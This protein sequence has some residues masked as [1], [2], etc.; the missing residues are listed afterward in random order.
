MIL[1]GGNRTGQQSSRLALAGPIFVLS[2]QKAGTTSINHFLESLGLATVHNWMAVRTVLGFDDEC[3]EQDSEANLRDGPQ[4]PSYTPNYH[5]WLSS[6]GAANMS[7]VLRRMPV[8]AWLDT[9]FYAMP[10]EF[11]DQTLP[12]ARFV[13]WARNSTSWADSMLNYFS[14][15]RDEPMRSRQFRHSYGHCTVSAENMTDF[16][17]AYEAHIAHVRNYFNAT[18]GRHARL[19]DFD[20]E[21]PTAGKQLCEFVAANP[22]ECASR[23]DGDSIPDE[24]PEDETPEEE[25]PPEDTDAMKKALREALLADADAE[26]E[27]K[28]DEN[29]ENNPVND[30]FDATTSTPKA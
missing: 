2:M 4:P 12:R 8:D 23:L 15:D 28:K 30:E 10:V 3:D 7:K 21:A 14:L 22:S 19:L 9:P 24:R 29:S 13:L 25:F 6:L 16:V 5:R 17:R 26:A 18:P 20:V 11:V 27:D 1:L